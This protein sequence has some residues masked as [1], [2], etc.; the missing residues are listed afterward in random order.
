MSGCGHTDLFAVY[1]LQVVLCTVNRHLLGVELVVDLA[2][3]PGDHTGCMML[4]LQLTVP[5]MCAVARAGKSAAVLLHK[6]V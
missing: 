4:Q 3:A 2:L 5:R 6:P 1:K